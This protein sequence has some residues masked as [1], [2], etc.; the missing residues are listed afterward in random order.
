MEFLQF[1]IGLIDSLIRVW[2]LTGVTILPAVTLWYALVIKK[3]I[4]PEELKLKYHNVLRLD[5]I[6]NHPQSKDRLM[7]LRRWGLTLATGYVTYL[8]IGVLLYF[9]FKISYGL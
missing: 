9:I 1:E 7:H 6:A 2:F 8:S 3:S 4:R 5:Y